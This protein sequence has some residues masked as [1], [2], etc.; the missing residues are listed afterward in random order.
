MNVSTRPVA[1][2]IA[3]LAMITI[4]TL[5]ARSA[6]AD[7]FDV[8]GTEVCNNT[9]V[10][11]SNTPPMPQPSIPPCYLEQNAMRPCNFAKAQSQ[12]AQKVTGVDPDIAG[13]WI[14]QQPSGP[15]VLEVSRNGTYKFHSEAG[16]GAPSHIGS[17][18]ASHGHW[19]L[20]A[21]SGYPGWVDGGTYILKLPDTWILTGR[22]GRGVWRR[23]PTSPAKH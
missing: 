21:N 1:R 11:P 4:G 8:G 9:N 17:F 14:Y 19:S 20:T 18:G 15:W 23:V 10:P 2:G 16:D 3:A 6:R 22:L 12:Q 5:A 7:C 13:T